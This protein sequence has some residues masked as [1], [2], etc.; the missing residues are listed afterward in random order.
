[1]R[2]KK[3][4]RQNRQG[5]RSYPVEG[6]EFLSQNRGGVVLM[7]SAHEEDQTDKHGDYQR[8]RSDTVLLI[9][10]TCLDR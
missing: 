2:E 5:F 1:M 10:S 4:M 3:K 7:A 6:V 8:K 9:P